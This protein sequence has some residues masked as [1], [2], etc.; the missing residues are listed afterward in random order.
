MMRMPQPLQDQLWPV[1]PPLPAILGQEGPSDI[2]GPQ[3]HLMIM[4]MIIIIMIMF[5]MM[6]IDHGHYP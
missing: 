6:I 2:V 3:P 4:M 5:M 1:E